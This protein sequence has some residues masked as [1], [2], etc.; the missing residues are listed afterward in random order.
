MDKN[1]L[2]KAMRQVKSQYSGNQLEAM[3]A[4]IV[5]RALVHEQ[6][7]KAST[8]LLYYSLP[9]EVD[10]HRLVDRLCEQ[11]KRVLLPKIVG[12]GQLELRQY[13]SREDMAEAASFHILEPIGNVFTDYDSIDTALIPGMAFDTSGH[14]LGRGKGYY[15]RLLPYLKRTYKIGVCFP[16]QKVEIVPTEPWDVPMDEIL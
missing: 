9:D 16:F 10:T 6:I 12:E 14:R 11:G 4:E 8:I 5:E 7:A 2:R 15:D 1:E 3:S 13:R